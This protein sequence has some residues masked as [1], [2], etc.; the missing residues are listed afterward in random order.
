M[1]VIF[2][3]EVLSGSLLGVWEISEVES[4]LLQMVNL[5][6]AEQAFF[7]E[8]KPKRR[9]KEWLAVRCLLQQLGRGAQEIFYDRFSKP[10]LASGDFQIGISHSS[11]LAVVMLGSSP[12]AVDVELC[13]RNI[14]PIR[15]K[16]LTEKELQ[17]IDNK[18]YNKHLLLH[19]CA[20]ETLY[21]LHGKKQLDFKKNLYIRSFLPQ[22]QG[23]FWGEI[24]LKNS[25]SKHR[26][27]YFQIADNLIVYTEQ[28]I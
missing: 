11:R 17:L 19:W 27:H 8:I 20:K 5:S 4:D 26:L 10:Y 13:G 9:R 23:R 15:H 2:K 18:Q 28:T 25:I 7:S 22:E 6:F 1:A 24:R 16:F 14:E 12:L 3:E 21:K